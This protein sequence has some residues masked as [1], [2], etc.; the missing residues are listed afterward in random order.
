MRW[1][2]VMKAV[3]AVGLCSLF[4]VFLST[5]YLQGSLGRI[6]ERIQNRRSGG[7]GDFTGEI[8]VGGLTRTYHV[9]LPQSYD[10]TQPA[11]L[12]LPFH[13]G[14]GR[15][16]RMPQLTGF[17]EVSDRGGFIVVYPE[18]VDRHWNDGRDTVPNAVDDVAFVSAL[19]DRLNETLSIDRK[20][21]YATG[22]S[23]GGFFAER[24]ACE[25]SNKIAAT[26]S[27]AATLPE[28]YSCRPSRP[29]SVLL[30]HGTD[31]PFV[32]YTGGQVKGRGTSRGGYGG[33][34]LSVAD[35]VKYWTDHDK[36]PP[37]AVTTRLEDRDVRDGTTVR[38]DIYVQ[39]RGGT[40]VVLYTVNGGGHTWPGGL[41]YAPEAFIG[42]TNRDIN[43]SQVIWDFFKKHSLN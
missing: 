43:A 28:N 38:R 21:V 16:E 34:A 31:D 12:V 6:R 22:I 23:N 40:E 1:S 32:P 39:C 4:L 41:Q 7:H 42:K 2:V 15:G 29:V 9:H 5:G 37:S 20:R 35:T 24:L 11:P 17:N 33:R 8:V 10:K 25:L 36:C 14:T 13:G 18:G 3:V 26:A 30:I 27:V 19:I